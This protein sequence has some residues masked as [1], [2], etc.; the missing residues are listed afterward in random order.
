MHDHE[1]RS[2][3]VEDPLDLMTAIWARPT[4]EVHGIVGGYVGPG[5][6]SAVP[7]RGE[8]KLSCRLVPN[9]TCTKTLERVAAFV[10]ERIPDAEVHKDARLEP[11]RGHTTGPYAEAV[12]EAYHFGFGSRPAFTRE[13]G[14]IGAV[15]TME[16]VLG[17]HVYFLGL[18]LPEHGY[19]A[20]N[21]NYDWEQASGGIPMFARYFES[22]AKIRSPE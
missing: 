18:S 13:G 7:A 19:H 11:Y 2:I 8:A 14:S 22:V 21:E 17:A 20:P 16:A 6:K 12:R 5:I 1:M 4:M 10:K 9:M 15:P 3:R